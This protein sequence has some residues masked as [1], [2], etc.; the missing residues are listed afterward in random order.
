MVKRGYG[1]FHTPSYVLNISGN[2]NIMKKI[3]NLTLFLFSTFSLVFANPGWDVNINAYQY[4]G[5]VTSSVA[6][7][8]L[9]IGAGDQ[10]GAFVDGEVRGVG[11]ATFF[12]PAG[13]WIF[14][15][16]I[17]SNSASGEMVDFKLYDSETDQIIDLNETLGFASDMTVGNGFAPFS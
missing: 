13:A 11:S 14:Q 4:N 1:E 10:L 9:D 6:V 5:S 15:T 3:N 12:P 16:M 8:G 2:V 17:F 7:D